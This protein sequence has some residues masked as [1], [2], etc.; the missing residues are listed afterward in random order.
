MK[1]KSD[2]SSSNYVIVEQDRIFL[3]VCKH[4]CGSS[5]AYCYAPDH[6]QTQVSLTMDEMA[7]VCIYVLESCAP[8]GKIISLCPN[9]E[10]LKSAESINRIL[11][12]LECLAPLKCDIQISTKESIPMDFLGR[13]AE[14]CGKNLFLNISIPTILHSKTWEPYAAS[15]EK[16]FE[17]FAHLQ[18]FP[19]IHSCLYIKPFLVEEKE[20]SLYMKQILRYHIS[21]VCLGPLFLD[22]SGT[23]CTSLYDSRKAKAIYHAQKSEIVRFMRLLRSSTS[24]AVFSSSICC[25]THEHKRACVLELYRQSDE[26]CQDCKMSGGKQ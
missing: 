11:Q 9:T 5:C 3:D 16:R 19:Q 2:I 7:D 22:F 20:Y 1:Q 8:A 13:A 14:L 12:V 23:P 17:N 10:P 6:E 15:V 25:I 18:K 26:L 21:T 4:G 24:A